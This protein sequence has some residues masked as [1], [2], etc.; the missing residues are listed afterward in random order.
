MNEALNNLVGRV[1]N[2]SNEQLADFYESDGTTLKADAI[3][4]LA[5]LDADR[6]K[7]IKDNLK[8]EITKKHDEGYSKGKVESLSKFEKQLREEYKIETADLKGV[9]LIKEIVSKNAKV[10]IDEEK[11]KLHPRYLELERKLT[12]DYLPKAEYDKLKAE[13]DEFK[14]TLEKT[15]TYSVIKDDAIKAFRE[16]KPVL[17]KDATRAL[18]Q[19][20]DFITKLLA[21]EYEIQ[22]NGA[23]IIKKD[24]KRLETANGYAVTFAD[25][26]KSEASKYFDFEVQDDKGNAGN[27]GNNNNSNITIPTDEKEYQKMLANETDPVKAMALVTAWKAKNNK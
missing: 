11:L 23:H 22:E 27:K 15:K 14:T 9:D 19:E 17:S 3:D 4:R 16:L 6:I 5:Q 20:N 26:I 10:E 25:F 1:L 21:Y 13:Y 18:N 7:G 24:G 2:I 8:E 12:N